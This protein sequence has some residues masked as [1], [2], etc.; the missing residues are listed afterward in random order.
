MPDE[1]TEL[2]KKSRLLVVSNRLPI[3][4]EKNEKGDWEANPGSG[5]LVTALAPVLKNRGGVWIGWPGVTGVSEDELH[6]A[7]VEASRS[8]GFNLMPVHLSEEEK[9][10]Y[11]NGAAN[12]MILPLFHDML[13]RCIFD[14]S[15]WSYYTRVNGKFAEKILEI[16]KK[17]DFIWIHDYHLMGVADAL[18]Q[19]EENSRIAFFLHT[20]FPTPDLFMRLPWRFELLRSLLQYDLIGLQTI[21]DQRNF[22]QCVRKNIKTVSVEGDGQVMA[23]DFGERN[24]RVGAFAISIDFKEFSS[25]AAGSEVA[26]K[27]NEIHEQILGAQNILGIDRLDYSKGIP[28]RLEAFRYALEKYPELHQ[29]V[30]LTQVVVPSRRNIPDYED[31]K[32]E[33]ERLVSDIN[34]EFTGFDWV[35]IRYIFRSLTRSELVAFYRASQVALIT[36]LKDGMNLIAKEYCASNV[37]ENGVLILSEFAGAAVQLQEHALIVNPHDRNG[38]AE[39]I[40]QA[41]TMKADERRQRMKKLRQEIREADIFW[42]VNA[43]LQASVSRSLDNFGE[44]DDYRPQIEI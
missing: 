25:V 13:C 44:I 20:P 29:K 22:I 18:R 31:L 23:L 6:S 43:F 33:I 38:V 11:Y 41:V 19:I 26:L 7:M 32:T 9:R 2:P 39:A 12:E 35:P 21:R 8:S 17:D 42:W 36:P 28:E 27:T 40:Y 24:V 16:R 14:E 4:L 10:K 37:D 34:G 3:V 5:G 1:R 15:Y 30:I